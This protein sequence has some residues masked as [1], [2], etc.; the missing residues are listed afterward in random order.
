MY[1]FEILEND[2]KLKNK[3][4][5]A[6]GRNKDRFGISVAITG[7][8]ILVGANA[9]KNDERNQISGASYIYE[10]VQNEW[11]EEYKIMPADGE[12]RDRF[13]SAVDLNDDTAAV[14]SVRIVNDTFLTSVY[15]FH[16][17]LINISKYSPSFDTLN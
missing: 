5:P 7:N 10:K 6:D 2:V 13:G 16:P 14:R 12:D 11:I 8:R 4:F 9:H 1:V 17:P 3:I 15:F